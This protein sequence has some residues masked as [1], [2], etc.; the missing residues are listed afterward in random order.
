MKGLMKKVLIVQPIHQ[1]GIDLLKGE[2]EVRHAGD[3]SEETVCREIRGVHGVVVRT[4]PF[5]E[6]II[7]AADCLKVIARHGVGV[8]NIAVEA[9][10][11]LSIFVVNTPHANKISVAEH[12]IGFMLA[13]AKRTVVTDRATRKNNFAIREEFST[14]DLEGKTLGIVGLGRIGSTVAEKCRTAFN[15]MVLACDPYLAEEKIREL[16]AE[17]CSSLEDLLRKADIVSI[18]VPLTEETAGLFGKREL[19]LMKRSAFLINMARG[20]IVDEQALARAL[21]ERYIAG[22]AT[23]VYVEEPPPPDHPLLKLDNIVLSP[24]MSALTKECTMR[25]ATGAAQGVLDVLKGKK[26]RCVVTRELLERWK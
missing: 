16:G 19:K 14:V 4:A 20:G 21:T 18:H 3:P 11:R 7:E 23:D 2:V 15:M 9:A 12:T 8:D 10:T 6:R 17:P 1:S 24:H 26:P 25:M 5:T 13:L 22:A